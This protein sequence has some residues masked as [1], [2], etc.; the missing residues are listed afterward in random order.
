MDL[1]LTFSNGR[2]SGEGNDAIGC[3]L[4][5]GSCDTASRE[6]NWVKQYVG[7][8]AVYYQG[9]AE[10]KG[11][12]GTWEIRIEHGGFHIWPLNSGS[13]D[14]LSEIEEISDPVKVTTRPLHLVEH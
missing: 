1:H 6:C 3:F 4:I 9:F 5:H 14:A 11:I 13:G 12:W 2:I 7:K 8:H 10:G